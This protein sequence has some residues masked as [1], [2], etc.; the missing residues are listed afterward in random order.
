MVCTSG[1]LA[2]AEETVAE[3]DVITA[4]EIIECKRTISLAKEKFIIDEQA[5][6]IANSNSSGFVNP[7]N[8]RKILYVD[9]PLA[10]NASGELFPSD[11]LYID[12]LKD[13]GIDFANS[14][15]ELKKLL[16]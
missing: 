5:G 3:L 6:R 7:Y 16:K 2:P 9:K 14:L 12:E 1:T 4:D 13:K 8:K 11:K 10:R 15:E